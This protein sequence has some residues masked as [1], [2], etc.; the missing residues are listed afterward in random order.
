MW[1]GLKKSY[2]STQHA[3]GGK[4]D[5]DD[6]IALQNGTLN[7]YRIDSE[8]MLNMRTLSG[9]PVTYPMLYATR[10]ATHIP[11]D[12]A[13]RRGYLTPNIAVLEVKWRVGDACGEEP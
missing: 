1:Y 9:S 2:F 13:A 10:P 7:Q 6:V 8:R 4:D 3:R 11:S 12:D 5:G